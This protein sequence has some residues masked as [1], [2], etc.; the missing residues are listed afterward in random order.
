MALLYGC[1]L[2]VLELCTYD[3]FQRLTVSHYSGWIPFFIA[4]ISLGCEFYDGMERNFDVW[5]FILRQVVEIRV[6]KVGIR[7][8]GHPTVDDLTHRH[9]NIA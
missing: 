2:L 3:I 1:L 5:Q 6:S 7:E 4:A 8:P 9:R